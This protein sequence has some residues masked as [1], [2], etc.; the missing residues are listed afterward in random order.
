MSVS[1]VPF[2]GTS[3]KSPFPGALGDIGMPSEMCEEVEILIPYAVLCALK[4]A[5]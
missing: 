3:D 5:C 2:L 4:A 1:K